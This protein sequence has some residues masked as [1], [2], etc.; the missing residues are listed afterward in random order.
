[1]TAESDREQ[2]SQLI[3]QRLDELR[4]DLRDMRAGYV[5]NAVWAQRNQHVDSQLRSV[6]REV[7]DLRTEVRAKSVPWPSVVSAVVSLVAI[8]VVMMEKVAAG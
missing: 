5:P 6:G 7:G 1:M 8:A 4:D 3:L 2:T